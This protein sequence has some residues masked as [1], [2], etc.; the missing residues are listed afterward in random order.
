MSELNIGITFYNI[1]SHGNKSRKNPDQFLLCYCESK[2]NRDVAC[3]EA[4]RLG[5]IC[6]KTTKNAFNA[7]KGSHVIQ[8]VFSINLESIK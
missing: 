3:T 8:Y 6:K 1:F 2:H 5:W 4:R 7:E